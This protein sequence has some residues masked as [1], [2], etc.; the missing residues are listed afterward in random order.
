MA[1]LDLRNR[2]PTVER[3]PD[4]RL[5]VTR[6]SDV[7]NFI[8]KKPAEL[9][10]SVWLAWGTADPDFPACRLT[11]QDVGGQ[12][13]D[14]PDD[15]KKPPFL[16]RIYDEILAT[17]E[18]IVG[19]PDVS[20]NQYGY[21]EV[22]F[23]WIQF[24]AGTAIYQV[25][26]TTAAPSPFSSYILR[27]Q[28]DTDDGTVRLIK[29]TYV[30]GGL[31]SDSEELKFGGKLLIRTRKSLL[32]PPST[33]T[34]FTLVTESTE[35]VNGCEVYSYGYASAAS[36][37]GAGG[38]ISTSVEYKI[39][40]DQGATGVTITT[41]RNVSTLSTSTNPI[42]GPAGSELIQVSYED[43]GGYRM[44]TAIYA[45]GTGVINS[46]VDIREGGK[47]IIYEITSINLPP[48]EPSSTIGGTVVLFSTEQRNG[49]DSANGTILYSYKWAEGYGE[50]SRTTSFNQ[51]SDEGTTGVTVI[52]IKALTAIGSSNPIS[53][54]SG[55]FVIISYGSENQNGYLLWSA[56]YAKGV[57]SVI[58]E[59]DQQNNGAL[60]IYRIVA[61]GAAPTPPADSYEVSS[62]VRESDGYQIFDYKW[63]KGEGEISRDIEYGQSVDQGVTNGT[64]KTTIRYLVAPGATIEPSSVG[65]SVLIKQDVTEGNGYRVWTT[66]WATGIGLVLDEYDIQIKNALVVY[67]RTG[68]NSA[69][70]APSSMIGGSVI[71][72]E[73]SITKADGYIIYNSRWYEGAGQSSIETRAEPDGALLY[74]VTTVTATETTPSYPGIGTAYLISLE[75]L[76]Q[77]GFYKNQA[78]YKKPPTIQIRKQTIPFQKPGLAYFTGTQL[79]LSPQTTRTILADV[80]VDYLEAQDT[81]TPWEVEAYASFVFN[82]T[83]TA[84]G[85][86]PSQVV[87]GQQG[88]SGYLSGATSVSGTN[89]NYNGVLCD[90]YSAVLVSSIPSS[91]PSGLTLLKVDNDPYLMATDGTIVWRITKV[92]YSF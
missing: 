60:T 3:L 58:T 25:P 62:S 78:I 67:H 43:D 17:S 73:S 59:I 66:S 69:P 30:E 9:I 18:T 26:G 91:R 53:N 85:T 35:Y 55:G 27:D 74:S 16:T 87:Q 6:V 28:Q 65:S 63:A 92:S 51:S 19:N 45:S 20:V 5:R 81:S 15:S 71:L 49:T 68:I 8:P 79:T 46:S 44:W 47:L 31:L 61:L 34:G 86:T 29:R 83:T 32:T 37:A 13:R 90:S 88:L 56:V 23:H 72:F 36:A 11:K 42:T 2:A 21:K 24:S 50:I 7:L 33:P 76:T 57:G 89:S 82:Y 80:E 48:T 70:S 1:N 38:N 77:G 14:F 12:Q 40:P 41:I 64:T 75:H 54:P 52:S 10:S 39:S 84:T 4:G 22:I